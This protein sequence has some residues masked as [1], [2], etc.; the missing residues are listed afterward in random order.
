MTRQPVQK[1]Q[2]RSSRRGP[3]SILA[4]IFLSTLIALPLILAFSA[5]VYYISGPAEGY[6][7]ADC[8][9]SLYWANASLESGSVFDETYNYA[10]LLPFSANLWMTPLIA[11]FGFGMTAQNLGMI[12]F[13]VVFCAS[14]FY[15]CRRAGMSLGWCSLTT[16]IVLMILSSSDKL[17]EIMLGHVIYYS[18]GLVLF[19]LMAGLALSTISRSEKLTESGEQKN[20]R[21]R[22]ML[23]LSALALFAVAAGS[24]ADGAQ[25]LA[26]A[27]LPA[28]GGIA[29]ERLT[30]GSRLLFSRKNAPAWT[31]LLIIIAGTLFGTLLLN[32][33]RGDI[34][35]GYAGVYSTYSDIGA[36]LS[37]AQKFP[38]EYLKLLGVAAGQGEPLFSLASI[39]SVIRIAVGILLLVLPVVMLCFYRHIAYRGTRVMLWSHLVLTAVTLFGYICGRLAN[40][41]WRLTPFVGSAAA[42]AVFA[43]WELS[44]AGRKKMLAAGATASDGANKS[45]APA[46]VSGNEREQA[47]EQGRL[48]LRFGIILTAALSLAALVSFGEIAKMPAD[49]GRDNAD[50]QLMELLEDNGL[51]YGYANFWRSNAIT[52]LSDSRVTVRHADVSPTEGLHTNHYQSSSR[53]YDESQHEKYDRYFVI[54]SSKDH[55]TVSRSGSW[56]QWMDTIFIEELQ[57]GDYRIFVFSEDLKLNEK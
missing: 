33:I 7:H 13:V 31:V 17:R 15:F 37:N 45:A 56:Q 22:V 51:E 6:F 36:W 38:T 10:A 35:A 21:D 55:Q 49:Y 34:V 44:H 29:A 54:L 12:I 4:G 20:T 3:G 30:D 24:A 39:M 19:F 48:L 1:T 41:N 18:L 27:T 2:K 40:A 42:L 43:A 52:V 28:L 46:A 26:L 14:L 16:G 11:A 5:A 50:H 53:W 8:S 25:I 47:L 9:D 32:I 23:V 57:C